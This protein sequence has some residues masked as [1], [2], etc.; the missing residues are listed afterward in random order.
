MSRY[1]TYVPREV[2]KIGNSKCIYPPLK[3]EVYSDCEYDRFKRQCEITAL[4]AFLANYDRIVE[5]EIEKLRIAYRRAKEYAEKR[6]KDLMEEVEKDEQKHQ[7][8]TCS[9]QEAV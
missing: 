3:G 2:V 8:Y 1:K 7:A 4:A 5:E 9:L 6:L